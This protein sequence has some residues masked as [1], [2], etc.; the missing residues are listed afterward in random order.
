MAHLEALQSIVRWTP[1]CVF[2]LNSDQLVTFEFCVQS[3]LKVGKSKN[4]KVYPTEK[5][6]S[7]SIF[8]TLTVIKYQNYSD[9]VLRLNRSITPFLLKCS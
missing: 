7:S 2:Q 3:K 1:C 5:L 6:V 9:D 8:S 4:N